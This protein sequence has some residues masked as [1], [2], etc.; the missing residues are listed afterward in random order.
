[1]KTF[2]H[3]LGR[4]LNHRQ[5]EFERIQ[6]ELSQAKDQMSQIQAERHLRQQSYEQHL[7]ASETAE[8]IKIEE[9]R[10][11]HAHLDY[12]RGQMHQQAQLEAHAGSELENATQRWMRARQDVKVLERHR[13]LERQAHQKDLSRQEQQWLDEI[14]N[15][16][17]FRKR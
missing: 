14:A 13:E 2:Q 3:S 15:Q 11:A 6:L 12:L 4:V 5:N 7:K 10:M 8:I 1:M 17:Y 9:L 16:Q